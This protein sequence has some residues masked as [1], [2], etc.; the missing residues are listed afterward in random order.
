MLSTLCNVQL[1]AKDSASIASSFK[2]GSKLVVQTSVSAVQTAAYRNV[3]R[4]MEVQ[5]QQPAAAGSESVPSALRGPVRSDDLPPQPILK[6]DSKPQALAAEEKTRSEEDVVDVTKTI[7]DLHE[8]IVIALNPIARERKSLRQ[9]KAELNVLRDELQLAHEQVHLSEARMG[10]ALSRLQEMEERLRQ[11]L[12]Q[13]DQSLYPSP[14]SQESAPSSIPAVDSFAS[15]SSTKRKASRKSSNESHVS[16]NKKG[17]NLRN[18]WYPVEFTSNLTEDKLIP[19]ELFDEPWVLF[20]GKDGLPGCVRDECAH[21]ACPLSLG[22]NVEGEIQCAYHGWRFDASGACKEMPSTRKCNAS[23]EALPCV[24]RSE[25]IFVWAGDGVPP[26]DDENFVGL[27]PPR[28]FDVHAEIVLEVD[29][30]HGLLMENLLDLAHAPFTHTSTFAKGWKVPNFVNFKTTKNQDQ[31]S[32]SS[33]G[34]TFP[35]YWDPYP[36]DMAFQPPCMVLSTI[37][38]AQPGKLENGVRAKQCDKHL[39]QLHVCLPAGSGKTRL[40]YRMGLD[41]AHFAKFVPFMDKFW[42]SLA[43]QVLGEDLV[44]VRGQMDRMKQGA[45]VWANPVSYDKLGVR[46]RRWRNEVEKGVASLSADHRF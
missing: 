26:V 45:D 2:S 22:K 14:S 34:G 1:R 44:L 32:S 41:F 33:V 6:R 30:E 38:L 11:S 46:Y 19:F 13:S 37:G 31:D 8:Q 24:E 42:L 18:F 15:A 40:L 25:M 23:I 29:V 5:D 12:P 10:H 27:N 7:L 4:A 9:A 39:H 20:R 21:R 35:G 43:N 17:G 16:Q 3:A 28:N 36:I